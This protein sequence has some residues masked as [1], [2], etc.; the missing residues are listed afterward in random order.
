MVLMLIYFLCLYTK[1]INNNNNASSCTL[2]RKEDELG[3]FYAAEKLEH[4]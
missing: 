4:G 2:M 1:G 3:G